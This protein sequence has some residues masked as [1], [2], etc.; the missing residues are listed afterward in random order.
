MT[1]PR[2]DASW[3][4]NANGLDLSP[5]VALE[6]QAGWFAIYLGWLQWLGCL[7]WTW[8]RR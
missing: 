8:R 6:W 1:R 3:E 4:R 7:S 5:V 2:F